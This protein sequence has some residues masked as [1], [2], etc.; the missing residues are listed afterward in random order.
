MARMAD[1]QPTRRQGR[2]VT[3][4]LLALFLFGVNNQWHPKSDSALYLATGRNLAEGQGYQ[5]N[6]GQP[7]GGS[8]GLPL[9]IAALVKAFGQQYW[10]INLTMSLMAW[11]AAVFSYRLARLYLDRRMALNILLLTALAAPFHD[12]AMSIESDLPATFFVIAA[13]FFWCRLAA[14]GRLRWL[15]VALLMIA[16]AALMRSVALVILLPMIV[17]LPWQ[18]GRTT[19]RRRIW[20]TVGVIGAMLAAGV[21]G[22][23]IMLAQGMPLDMRYLEAAWIRLTLWPQMLDAVGDA[24]RRTPGMLIELLTGQSLPLL[25]GL[26]TFLLIVLGLALAVRRRW[27]I[28]ALPWLVYALFLALFWGVAHPRYFIPMLPVTALLLLVGVR[29]A[30]G[31]CGNARRGVL[32]VSLLAGML[33]IGRAHV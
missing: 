27:L 17:V 12:A 11:G 4:V 13:I 24:V 32:A 5:V 28:I 20:L 9:M 2:I 1:W 21:A 23:L 8:P 26:P 22:W 16:L 14:D 29:A 31:C 19:F 33:Q 25:E 10:P 30:F 18:S 7:P 6:Y 3:V 15:A